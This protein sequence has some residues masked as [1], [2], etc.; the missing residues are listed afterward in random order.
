MK[1][2]SPVTIAHAL[3]KARIREDWDTYHALKKQLWAITPSLKNED[4]QMMH[5]VCAIYGFASI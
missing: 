2:Q 5:T 4:Y 3:C 1:N